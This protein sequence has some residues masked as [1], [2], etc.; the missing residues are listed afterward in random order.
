MYSF[1]RNLHTVLH[2]SPHRQ[3]SIFYLKYCLFQSVYFLNLHLGIY[4]QV[5]L[6]TLVWLPSGWERRLCHSLLSGASWPIL[7]YFLVYKC[8]LPLES[9]AGFSAITDICFHGF[10]KPRPCP[11]PFS[12]HPGPQSCFFHFISL[13]FNLFLWTNESCLSEPYFS[14]LFFFPSSSSFAY[15]WGLWKSEPGEKK[16][17]YSE[18]KYH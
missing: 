5:L 18:L 4:C 10:S 15:V 6:N 11:S 13:E 7:N 8:S 1:L 14:A 2:T 12:E 17:K 3:A 16:N 9:L